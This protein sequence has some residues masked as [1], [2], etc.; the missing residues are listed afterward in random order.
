MKEELN[1]VVILDTVMTNKF[2]SALLQNPK[3][4]IVQIVINPKE[5]VIDQLDKLRLVGKDAFPQSYKR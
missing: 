2:R 4:D 1:D 3:N 5:K